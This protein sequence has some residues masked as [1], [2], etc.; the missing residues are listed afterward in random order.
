MN[1]IYKFGICLSI[2]IVSCTST[3]PT[4]VPEWAGSYRKAC[5]PEAIAVSEGLRKSGVQAK[6]LSIHTKNW[7]HATCA[8]LYP[9]GKNRL[10]VWD[11]QWQSVPLRAWWDDPKDIAKAWMKWRYDETPVENAWFQDDLSVIELP[12]R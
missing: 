5:L 9:P 1:N 10:W 6:V 3:P 2:F 8:Y 7:G 4:G 12:E 11:S